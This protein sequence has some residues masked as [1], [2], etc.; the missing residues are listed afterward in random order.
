MAERKVWQT[1]NLEGNLM[2]DDKSN[3]LEEDLDEINSFL[4]SKG[5]LFSG[6]LTP[7]NFIEDE[8]EIKCQD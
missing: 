8:K 7:F 1:Y 6:S 2:K 4:M 3:L 5:I